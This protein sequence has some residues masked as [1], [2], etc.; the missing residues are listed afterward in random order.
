MKLFGMPILFIFISTIAYAAE[1]KQSVKNTQ[2]KDS[3]GGIVTYKPDYTFVAA[4]RQLAQAQTDQS[5]NRQSD[6]QNSMHDK[7]HVV[8]PSDAR[9]AQGEA[10]ESGTGDM[11]FF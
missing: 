3:R 2:T 10:Q 5:Q 11:F 9:V 7:E 4:A 8:A 6:P 1:Q